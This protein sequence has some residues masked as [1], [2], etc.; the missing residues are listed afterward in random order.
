MCNVPKVMPGSAAVLPSYILCSG[1]Y[2]AA[3]TAQHN[4]PSSALTAGPSRRWL[5]TRRQP[6]CKCTDRDENA[7]H[8]GDPDDDVIW[9]LELRLVH[10]LDLDLERALVVQS[11]HS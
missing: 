5:P 9:M 8:G 4:V 2:G 7:T 3:G 10:L 6:S 1:E 11:L